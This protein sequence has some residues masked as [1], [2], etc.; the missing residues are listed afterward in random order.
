MLTYIL[1]EN[2]SPSQVRRFC[3]TMSL[4]FSKA[5]NNIRFHKNRAEGAPGNFPVGKS[6]SGGHDPSNVPSHQHRFD[7][8]SRKK[9]NH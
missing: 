6:A 9:T 3:K 8:K 7:E 2:D 1:A 4:P 5:L